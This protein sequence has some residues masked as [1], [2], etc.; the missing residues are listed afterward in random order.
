MLAALSIASLSEPA[1][2]RVWSKLPNYTAWRQRYERICPWTSCT[3]LDS[4][5]GENSEPN[6]RK[7]STST[8]TPTSQANE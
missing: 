7:S 3:A 8:T 5:T 4:I 1:F 6:D 2:R